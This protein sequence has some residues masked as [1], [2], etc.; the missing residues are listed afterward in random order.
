MAGLLGIG[1]VIIVAV[2]LLGTFF[3]SPQQSESPKVILVQAITSPSPQ[4]ESSGIGIFFL[5]LIAIIAAI[6]FLPA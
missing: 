2:T 6:T 4:E 1:L 3:T 5:L